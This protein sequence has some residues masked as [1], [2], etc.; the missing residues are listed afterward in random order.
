MK[1]LCTFFLIASSVLCFFKMSNPSGFSLQ[2]VTPETIAAEQAAI[3]LGTLE[4]AVVSGTVD[5]LT[6]PLEAAQLMV[7]IVDS[8]GNPTG[9][10]GIVE[11][12]RDVVDFDTGAVDIKVEAGFP[13]G[14][15]QRLRLDSEESSGTVPLYLDYNPNGAGPVEDQMRAQN[16]HVHFVPPKW[17][18]RNELTDEFALPSGE[19]LP[20]AGR[21]WTVRSLEEKIEALIDG[22]PMHVITTSKPVKIKSADGAQRTLITNSHIVVFFPNCRIEWL[23]EFNA[24][25]E[26][27]FPRREARRFILASVVRS[28][29]YEDLNEDGVVSGGLPKTLGNFRT[30]EGKPIYVNG[31][32]IPARKTVSQ[33]IGFNAAR[34]QE[35][36]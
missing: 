27:H 2:Q 15:C 34:F 14:K 17:T 6:I 22:A 8:A 33:L 12:R 29:P 31:A 7:R 32:S 36:F 11:A 4:A 18:I 20:S 19:H 30:L 1:V 10:I 9:D 25:V 35:I 13:G 3:A 28:G 21:A 5:R 23:Q 26:T 24:Y 16:E